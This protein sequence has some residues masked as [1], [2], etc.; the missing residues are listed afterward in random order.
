MVMLRYAL[1]LLGAVLCG[2]DLARRLP[3][4]SVASGIARPV[5]RAFA[6]VFAVYGTRAPL[7]RGGLSPPPSGG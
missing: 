7:R 6:L 3:G 1:V 4:C 5:S 2:L